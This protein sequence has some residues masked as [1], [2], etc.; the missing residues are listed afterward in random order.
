MSDF[1]VSA[2][3]VSKRFVNHTERATSLKE[4][5]VRRGSK[6]GTDFWALRDVSVDIKHGETVGLIGRQRLGQ[7]DTAEGDGRHPARRP[8]DEIRSSGPDRVAARTR[9]GLQRRTQRPR[10]RL[11]QRLPA[12][13][14]SARD[15]RP[16][17]PDRRVLRTGRVHRRPG[18]ALFLGHVRP[19]WLRG[20]R[21][22][23]PGH[24]ARRR[25]ARGRRRST[26]S[27][28]V[29]RRSESSRA[30]GA[31]SCSSATRAVWSRRCAAGRSFSTTAA[32]CLK[33]IRT[34]LRPN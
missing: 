32:R 2:T 1:A 16:L 10:E 15:R 20:G 34:S 14:H 7:V 28:S 19:A 17:R 13:A 6:S 12:R 4:R 33:A 23:R 25:G 27:A 22:R 24:P 8:V 3:D 21:A 31:R 5:V 29:W 30:R 18:E 26:S 9:R 11:P